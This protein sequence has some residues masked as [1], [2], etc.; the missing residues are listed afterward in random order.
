MLTE[1]QQMPRDA[2]RDWARERSPVAALRRLRD[3]GDGRGFDPALWAE[4]GQMG[5]TGVLVPE[6]HGGS[7]FG[8]S[9]LALVLAETGR[10]LTAS[11]LLSTAVIGASALTLAGS[12][13]QQ[14]AWLPRIASGEAVVALA[15]E[16]GP[17]HAPERIALLAEPADGGWRLAGEKRFVP[18]GGDADLFIV[19]ARGAGEPDAITLFLVPAD[20]A[21]ATPRRMAD[22]RGWADVRFDAA[23][24]DDAVLGEVGAGRPVLEA[25]LDR[26]RVALAAEMLGSAAEAFEIT[27]AYLK[28]R[29]Q[30]GQLIGGFQALQHRAA[31]MFTQLELA[32][33]CVEAAAAAVDAGAPD[34]PLL[35]SLAKAKAN[36]VLHLVSNEM[37]QMH[38]GI[39][40]TDEHE[41]GFY[42]KRARTAEALYGSSAWHRDR[43]ARLAGF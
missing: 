10:T 35:A 41:A 5:W 18:E 17:H 21:S 27:L 25:V 7:D 22:S 24:A 40:M 43:Y 12:E 9:A 38:G 20:A 1:E 6:A 15:V 34:L 39:G 16:E 8:F 31:Q 26:A 14:A 30:F 23:L 37:V 2:A 29:T 32:R 36:D 33:S 28:T 11:P 13:A 19:A 3:S 42:L 4:M